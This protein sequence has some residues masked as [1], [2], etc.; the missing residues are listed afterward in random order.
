MI[1]ENSIDQIHELDLVEVVKRYVPDLKQKGAKYTGCCPF[2]NEKTPSFSVDPA[3][4]IYKCFGCGEG[5]KD[6]IKFMMSLEK[7]G[8][9][10]AVK[11][12]AAEFNIILEEKEDDPDRKEQIMKRDGYIKLNMAVK[13]KYQKELLTHIHSGEEIKIIPVLDELFNRRKLTRETI[14]LFEIGYAPIDWKTITPNIIERG[15]YEAGVELGLIATKNGNTYDTYRGRIIF[16]IQ[17]ERGEIIGFGGR[18]L[19]DGKDD[20]PKYINSADSVLYKKEQVLY[21]I[22]QAAAA[23]KKMRYAT[24]V[25]GYFDVTAFHQAGM[26]NA[27]APCGTALTDGHA[28]LL[29]KYTNN[30][31]LMGDGD[32]AGMKANLKAV[33]L[34]LKHN[35]KVEICPLP[36]GHDPDSFAREFEYVEETAS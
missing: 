28:K 27:V 21:G 31:L 8:F 26:Q 15:L 3:K 5:G 33:D 19:E 9:I 35:F 29:K 14:S 22:Y 1:S 16:P 11:R 36:P 6:G 4:S 17:N 2:H 20:N 10:D 30:I 25:E 13:E 18:K 23:I 24:I 32:G 7:I 12:L 34:L